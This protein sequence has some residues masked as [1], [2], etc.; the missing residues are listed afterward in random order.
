MRPGM[1]WNFGKLSKHVAPENKITI[2]IRWIF[3]FIPGYKSNIDGKNL[4]L[5][6]NVSYR[7]NLLKLDW[8]LPGNILGFNDSQ[9]WWLDPNTILD[10]KKKNSITFSLVVM[11]TLNR[12]RVLFLQ[13]LTTPTGPENKY[14]LEEACAFW[15]VISGDSKHF[16]EECN[17]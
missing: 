11:R 10:R 8:T 17:E 5:Q 12:C 13:P 3:H 4:P 7:G 16:F 15:F 14:Y 1:S 2:I 9:I 6:H